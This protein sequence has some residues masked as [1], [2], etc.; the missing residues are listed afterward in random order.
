MAPTK[1]KRVEQ[2]YSVTLKIKGSKLEEMAQSAK[3]IGV[4]VVRVRK[5]SVMKPATGQWKL[6]E[7]NSKNEHNQHYRYMVWSNTSP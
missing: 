1:Q 3:K 2:E 4:E 5:A 6:T 7:D